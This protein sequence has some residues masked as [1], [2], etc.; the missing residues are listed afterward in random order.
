MNFLKK[1]LVVIASTTAMV[2]VGCQKTSLLKA[3]TTAVE[4]ENSDPYHITW[5]TLNSSVPV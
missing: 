2:F 3:S 4:N 5:H 1:H